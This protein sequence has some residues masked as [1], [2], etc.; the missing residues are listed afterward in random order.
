VKAVAPGA[1]GLRFVVT[2]DDASKIELECSNPED[3][4]TWFQKFQDCKVPDPQSGDCAGLYASKGKIGEGVSSDV[5]EG[6][7]RATGAKVAIKN[8]VKAKYMTT[9]RT[10][11]T[12]RR[13]IDIMRK[14]GEHGTHPV[15]LPPHAF[16]ASSQNTHGAT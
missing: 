2:L 12:T 4:G 8:I 5:H 15:C 1:E 13:E 10:I 14:I 7:V 3:A 11:L 9:E 6:V 16:P